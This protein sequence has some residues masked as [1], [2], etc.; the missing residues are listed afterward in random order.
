MPNNLEGNKLHLDEFSKTHFHPRPHRTFKNNLPA[1]P[2]WMLKICW[3]WRSNFLFLSCRCNSVHAQVMTVCFYKNQ[4]NRLHCS[5]LPRCWRRVTMLLPVASQNHATFLLFF[6]RF[7][8]WRFCCRNTRVFWIK[9]V[10][11]APRDRPTRPDWAGIRAVQNPARSQEKE[12][13]HKQTNIMCVRVPLLRNAPSRV[14]GTLLS[15][16]LN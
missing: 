6:D 5:F 14:S 11:V 13:E 8:L 7:D 12:M 16:A 15:N 10:M 1:S 3:R 9:T 2:E 4:W